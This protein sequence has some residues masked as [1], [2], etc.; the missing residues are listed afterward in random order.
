MATLSRLDEKI[1]ALNDGE[2]TLEIFEELDADNHSFL[3]EW[4]IDRLIKEGL[5]PK[6]LR[7][8]ILNLR[9]AIKEAMPSLANI[10][11]FRNDS[12]WKKIR[13]EA[14]SILSEIRIAKYN[15]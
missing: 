2:L 14:N 10:T 12:G 13:D 8:R 3:H 15:C 1:L 4:T 9:N 6:E 5:I 11:L 7:K